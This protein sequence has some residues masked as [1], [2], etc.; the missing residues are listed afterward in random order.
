MDVRSVKA[1]QQT[2]TRRGEQT[3]KHGDHAQNDFLNRLYRAPS[4]RSMFIHC[5]VVT[6]CVQDGDADRPI[7]ID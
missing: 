5:G 7:R 6:G 3:C 2:C 4:L 1:Q